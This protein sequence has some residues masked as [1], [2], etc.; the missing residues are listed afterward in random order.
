MRA[1]GVVLLTA[2]VFLGVA[3]AFLGMRRLTEGR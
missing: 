1:R 3:A 2:A